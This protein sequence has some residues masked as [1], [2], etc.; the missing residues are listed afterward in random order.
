LGGWGVAVQ[1]VDWRLAV[2]VWIGGLLSILGV[3]FGYSDFF[4]LSF[5]EFE[6]L[7]HHMRNV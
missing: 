5:M 2:Q 1:L 6:K 7:L 3:A 4:L